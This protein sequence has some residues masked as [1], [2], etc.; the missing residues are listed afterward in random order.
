M[1][2]GI[3]YTGVGTGALIVNDAGQI[4][5]MLRGAKSRNEPHHWNIP[6]GGV[7]FGELRADAIVREVKEEVDL[8][9]EIVAELRAT[10]HHIPGDSAAGRAP[11]YWITT[12]FVARMHP[13]QT[14]R[15][16]EPEKCEELGWFDLDNLPEQ[17]L[18]ASSLV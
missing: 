4:L 7:S 17:W 5:M 14:P 16:M 13:G 6:G 10:D 11:Q 15:I 9:V 1:K 18:L 2:P 12:P 3:D 8:D